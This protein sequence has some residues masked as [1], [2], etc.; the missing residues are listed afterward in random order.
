[1]FSH[2]L[3]KHKD[4]IALATLLALSIPLSVPGVGFAQDFSAPSTLHGKQAII[5]RGTVFECR[6]DE[7]IGSSRSKQGEKFSLSLASPLLANGTDVLIPAG[8]QV[9]GEVVEA[10]PSG[11]LKHEKGRPKPTG[12]LRVSLNGLRTPDGVT[13]PLVASI[14]GET[15][16]DSAGG[17]QQANTHLN[18]NVGYIGSQASFE[19]VAPGS[20]NKRRG[21]SGGGGGRGPQVQTRDQIMKDPI[22]GI[23]REQNSNG[24]AKIRSLTKKG[25][26]LVIARGA[27]VIVKI[28]APF[29]IGFAQAAG[30][31]AALRPSVPME[32]DGSFG[33]RFAKTR[34][35]E[36]QQQMQ[37]QQQQQAA[38][39]SQPS[40][41]LPGI[42][43]DTP[44]G[45]VT[46]APPM[47]AQP[48]VLQQGNA[49]AQGG[50][51]APQPVT[52]QQSNT[53]DF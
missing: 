12:K 17:R 28:D 9:L 20:D 43:P 37:Q 4:L 5:P 8:A 32:S 39:P 52:T 38:E 19:A 34:A 16:M 26:E 25:N 27:P 24:L 36:E 42:L 53:N 21:S 46:T 15:F 30:A 7:G 35:P 47:S 23:D 50:P 51:A 31:E 41:P 18:Q 13:Y 40:N 44:H 33:K 48:P 11:H 6:M 3:R 1:M 14:T 45:S 29:K 2:A 49:G 10:I 22:L